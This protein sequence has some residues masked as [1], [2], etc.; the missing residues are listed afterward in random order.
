[1][2]HTIGYLLR[3]VLFLLCYTVKRIRIPVN[4]RFVKVV[5]RVGWTSHSGWL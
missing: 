5:F 4:L 3:A 2:K 1:M